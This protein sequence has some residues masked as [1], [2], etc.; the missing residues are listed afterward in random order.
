[1]LSR[2]VPLLTSRDDAMRAAALRAAGIW[3]VPSIQARLAGLAAD[4]DTP[5]AVRAAAI[6]AMARQGKAEGR[7]AI[8]AIADRGAAREIQAMALSALVEID[9]DAAAN[10]IA[11]WLGKLP[12][13]RADEARHVLDVVLGRRGGPAN[14]AREIGRSSVVLPADLAKLCI[15]QVR[16]T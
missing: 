13:D 7:R 8:E 6:E 1:D 10:R 5:R 4:A 9:S 12:V 16:A 15:R 2:I 14:L 3:N 11:A